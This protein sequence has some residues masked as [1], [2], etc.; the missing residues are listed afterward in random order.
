MPVN[1][2]AFDIAKRAVV[3]VGNGRGFIVSAGEHERYIITAA[4]CLPRGR[5]PSPHLAN[6]AA[7]LTFE[8]FIGPLG[9]KP[10]QRTIWAELCFYSLAD[11]VA[12]FAEPDGQVLW[13]E[14][15]E[16]QA[17]TEQAMKIGRS[18]CAR[19][20]YRWT[21]KNET[22]AWL[23]SLEGQWECCTVQN[24]GRYLSVQQGYRRIKPGM[25]GSCIVDDD[26][27][28]IGAVSTSSA[29]DGGMHPS[30]MDCLPPWLVRKLDKTTSDDE[31][32][33]FEANRPLVELIAE[34]M[35][36]YDVAFR[37][38]AIDDESFML[39]AERLL[40]SFEA[41]EGRPAADYMEIEEWSMRHL[42]DVGPARFL[43]LPGGKK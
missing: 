23:L 21:A 35:A 5:L 24:S 33:E 28:A 32:E 25:S 15:E 8:K 11:D 39:Q 18:P 14:H 26:G 10:K 9:S 38:D 37:G 22:P 6:G 2:Q 41:I 7:D 42:N 3:Q 20:P 4:H 1:T 16:Y 13:D 12:V 34:N 27:A 29:G 43:V 40:R 31:E 36:I 19:Q 30:L 17:F